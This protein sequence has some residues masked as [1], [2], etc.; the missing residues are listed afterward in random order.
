MKNYKVLL[1]LVSMI[2]ILNCL[3]A[4][5]VKVVKPPQQESLIIRTSPTTLTL[6]PNA[7]LPANNT[8]YVAESEGGPEKM[9]K[10]GQKFT[11]LKGYQCVA[12][13]C[14]KELKGNTC[15]KCKKSKQN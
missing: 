15:W 2:L 13:V 11:M 12:Y 6:M 4:Q 9:F 3:S 8:F 1:I 10:G 7:M 5:Q 14:P